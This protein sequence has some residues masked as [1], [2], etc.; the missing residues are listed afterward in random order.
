ME[1]IYPYLQENK[2]QNPPDVELLNLTLIL[3][4]KRNLRQ[5]PA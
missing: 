1:T 5:Y 3:Q 2:L 4:L